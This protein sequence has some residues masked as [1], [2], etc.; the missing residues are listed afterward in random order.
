MYLVLK[1]EQAET[2]S[3]HHNDDPSW[4]VYNFWVVK[5]NTHSHP[6]YY[7][8]RPGIKTY[9]ACFESQVKEI[10]LNF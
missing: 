9:P 1:V 5:A 4:I 6:N 2:L 3:T 8:K 7:E 10:I